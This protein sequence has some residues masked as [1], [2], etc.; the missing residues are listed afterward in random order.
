MLSLTCQKN[1][2]YIVNTVLS[3][4]YS[5]PKLG[6]VNRTHICSIDSSKHVVMQ[7]RDSVSS[8]VR[9]KN[10]RVGDWKDIERKKLIAKE[11]QELVPM[12]PNGLITI[13][14]VVLAKNGGT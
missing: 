9:V 14:Q 12:V 5:T 8:E 2:F 7:L 13:K 11:S 10:L 3:R 1:D 4:Y 6:S